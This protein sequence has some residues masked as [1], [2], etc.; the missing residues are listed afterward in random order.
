MALIH[1]CRG[2][3]SYQIFV[4]ASAKPSIEHLLSE[5][6]DF[7]HQQRKSI[8]EGGAQRLAAV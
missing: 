2:L 5:T 8:E 7:S 6:I 3:F 4:R 1:V